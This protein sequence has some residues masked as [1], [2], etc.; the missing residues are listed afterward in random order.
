[1][2]VCRW[3][4]KHLNTLPPPPP[5]QREPVSS[6]A[7]APQTE[8]VIII[9]ASSSS[10]SSLAY[11]ENG[12]IIINITIEI[13][14]VCIIPKGLLYL[15]NHLIISS[16]FIPELLLRFHQSRKTLY[17]Y[18]QLYFEVLGSILEYLP[19]KK[20]ESIDIWALPFALLEQQIPGHWQRCQKFVAK[21][22]PLR[23]LAKYAILNW[24]WFWMIL[25]MTM[26]MTRLTAMLIIVCAFWR[27]SYE[28]GHHSHPELSGF[29]PIG[30]TE[31]AKTSM[32]ICFI[33]IILI[34]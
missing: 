31:V 19:P 12:I 15:R 2:F 27:L 28:E 20:E 29:Q 24:V 22:F 21:C 3:N 8:Y 6:F 11:M 5:S 14:I 10:L 7:P 25:L 33:N 34:S 30:R 32:I 23:I 9:K 18:L 4:A 16:T 17:L 1:M 13:V 26:S